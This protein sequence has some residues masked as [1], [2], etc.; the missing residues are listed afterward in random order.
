MMDECPVRG[1]QTRPVGQDTAKDVSLHPEG[2]LRQEL[3]PCAI[4]SI[5]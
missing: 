2:S 4:E 3:H 1:R 5:G